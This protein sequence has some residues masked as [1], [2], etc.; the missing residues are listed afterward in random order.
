MKFMIYGRMIRK[1]T[2][3]GDARYKYVSRFDFS[4]SIHEDILADMKN[5]YCHNEF[6]PVYF[7][8]A[9]KAH[10]VQNLNNH[11]KIKFLYQLCF[12]VF[13]SAEIKSF[14]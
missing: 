13:P 4:R 10:L 11:V 3:S 7:L 1:L 2:N 6:V 14:S 8:F 12:Q 5:V 9:F